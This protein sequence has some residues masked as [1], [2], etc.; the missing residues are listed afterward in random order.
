MPWDPLIA[1][2]EEDARAEAARIIEEAEEAREAMLSKAGAE[3][4]REAGE[5]LQEIRE[6]LQRERAARLNAARTA[7]SGL[8]LGV[9]HGLISGVLDEA[10]QRFSSMPEDEYSRFLTRL[11]EE[12]KLDWERARPGEVPVVCLNP[13]DLDRIRADGA[14]LKA[15]EGVRS[16][17]VFTSG[18]GRVRFEN[19]AAARMERA[20]KAM[21]PALNEMLFNEVF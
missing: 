13:A 1:A 16:G 10:R 3:A 21:V 17:V 4:E 18:D 20:G 7:A 2:L 14:R 8:R 5:R 19:T 11:Y 6:R 15:D 9:R 12:L